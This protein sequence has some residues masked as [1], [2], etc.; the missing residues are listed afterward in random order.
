MQKNER[1]MLKM[2]QLWQMVNI[3]ETLKEKW[4]FT[5]RTPFVSSVFALDPNK[6]A[7]FNSLIL[8]T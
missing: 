8:K 2:D 1:L 6:R 7:L 5:T 4:L 3:Y